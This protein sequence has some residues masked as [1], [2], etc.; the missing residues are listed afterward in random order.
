M[1]ALALDYPMPTDPDKPMPASQVDLSGHHF[2]STNTTPVFELNSAATGARLGIVVGKK[3]ANSTAPPGSPLGPDG[4]GFGSVAW[5][6]LNTT[7]ASVS[8]TGKEW[9]SI[10]RVNTAGGSPPK[11]C[12]GISAGEVIS[13]EY[14]ANYWYFETA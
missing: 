9:K 10:Y 13:I 6:Q 4:Q 12:D 5:L 3:S 11:T 8:T 1:P 7:N 14:A 2:F